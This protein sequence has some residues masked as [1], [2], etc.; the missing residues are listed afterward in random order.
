VVSNDLIDVG[1]DDSEEGRMN[2]CR[3]AA[4]IVS[5]T[6]TPCTEIMDRLT[7]LSRIGR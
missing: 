7:P 4:L 3:A 6:V 2:E 1:E 5:Y